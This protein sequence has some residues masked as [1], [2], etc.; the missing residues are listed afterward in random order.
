MARDLKLKLGDSYEHS[1]RST[2]MGLQHRQ[3][4]L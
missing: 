2:T 4:F 1:K 3:V